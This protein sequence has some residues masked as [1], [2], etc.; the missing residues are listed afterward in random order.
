MTKRKLEMTLHPHGAV[1]IV[2]PS[3]AIGRTKSGYTSGTVILFAEEAEQLRQ[4]L[5]IN[6]DD[7]KKEITE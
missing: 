4:W 6:A 2:V 3:G 7:K 5:N 1:S